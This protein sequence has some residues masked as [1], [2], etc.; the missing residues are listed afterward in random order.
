MLDLIFASLRI[1]NSA[2]MNAFL[3][4]KRL[5]G[6][7]S[8]ISQPVADVGVVYNRVQQATSQLH[9]GVVE[10]EPPEPLN[11]ID[12]FIAFLL[13]VLIESGLIEVSYQSS[14]AP[15]HAHCYRPWS[16]R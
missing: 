14:D 11:I 5:T 4:G 7:H 16:L 3:E 15:S 1:K 9:D 10:E 8:G 6:E 13:A 12:G 2:W